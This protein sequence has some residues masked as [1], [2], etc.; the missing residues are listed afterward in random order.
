MTIF[1]YALIRGLRSPFSIACNCI[2][3]IALI[4]IRPLWT[5]DMTA[6]FFFIAFVIIG[7]TLMMSQ[8]IL[9]D[10]I[11][12]TVIRILAAP[13]TMLHYLV[14]NLLAC[15][16]PL[17]FQ[18]ILICI[19]GSALYGWS[20]GF[21]LALFLCYTVFSLAS[22]SMAF[23]WH[24]LFKD[25]DTSLNS[26]GILATFMALLG[27]LFTPLDILPDPLQ[28]LGAIFPV[29]W[30]A[31]G[32][33]A[34]LAADIGSYVSGDYW[35]SLAAMLLFTTAYLLYGGKRRII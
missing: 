3:P 16:V 4:L 21:S 35:L 30:A 18:L 14:A 17:L 6:G 28:Y 34:I 15:M 33:D 23:A 8:S 32:L 29:Y 13:V 1:R 11:G 9:T 7:G 26:F 2:L 10:K 5:G 19:L 24:C 22:V 31:R 20:T 27:G 25:R 12:G